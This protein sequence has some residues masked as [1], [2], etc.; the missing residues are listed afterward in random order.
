MFHLMVVGEGLT[1]WLTGAGSRRL[2]G[3][4]IGHGMPKAWPMLASD[5]EPH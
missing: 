4:D 2:E 5:V 3:T 1:P